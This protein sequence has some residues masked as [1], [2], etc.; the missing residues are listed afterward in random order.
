MDGLW[1]QEG[2]KGQGCAKDVFYIS[3]LNN[4]V[5]GDPVFGGRWGTWDEEQ[6]QKGWSSAV[7]GMMSVGEDVFMEWSVQG[8]A[9]SSLSYSNWFMVRVQIRINKI[10]SKTKHIA[11]VSSSYRHCYN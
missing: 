2:D 7:W 3:D 9:C 1:G 6:T 11:Q 10:T 5:P 8:L 4:W